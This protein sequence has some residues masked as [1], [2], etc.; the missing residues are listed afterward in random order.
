MVFKLKHV[1]NTTEKSMLL[2]IS[3]YLLFLYIMLEIILQYAREVDR[4][5]NTSSLFVLHTGQS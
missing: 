2:E 3:S 1:P 4:G 5:R